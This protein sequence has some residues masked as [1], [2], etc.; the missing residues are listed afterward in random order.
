MRL[1]PHKIKD[2]AERLAVRLESRE[3]TELLR[4]RGPVAREIAAAITEDLAG[5]DRLDRE[6]ASVLEQYRAQIDGGGMDV[7]LL[8]DKIKK[9]LARERGIVL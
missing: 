5:E 4:G 8:R 6:V 9:Q 3:G 2:L 7:A 1:P